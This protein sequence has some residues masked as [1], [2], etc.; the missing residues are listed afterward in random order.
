M[1][2]VRCGA[3]LLQGDAGVQDG[4]A[5]QRPVVA[6]GKIGRGNQRSP[7]IAVVGEAKALGHNAHDGC[8]LAV[9]TH[10]M[11]NDA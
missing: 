5:S 2:Q 8:G 11:A 3:G 10:L 4:V 7:K 6:L 1:R 9:D